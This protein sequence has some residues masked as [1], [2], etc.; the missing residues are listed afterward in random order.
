MKKLQTIPERSES[1]LSTRDGNMTASETSNTRD[2]ASRADTRMDVTSV[3]S[4]RFG[5]TTSLDGMES[6]VYNDDFDAG[7][8]FD[9]DIGSVASDTKL[10]GE[11]QAN[12]QV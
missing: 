8:E 6:A 3:E 11:T 5:D 10:L 9:T 1:P 4:A 7:G 12:K 2:M